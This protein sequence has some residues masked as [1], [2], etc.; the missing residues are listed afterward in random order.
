[1]VLSGLKW[2]WGM[3][4]GGARRDPLPRAR[5]VF[6]RR[7]F[8]HFKQTSLCLNGSS[9][10]ALLWPEYCAPQTAR[11]THCALLGLQYPGTDT[12]ERGLEEKV[13]NQKEVNAKAVG[14]YGPAPGCLYKAIFWTKESEKDNYSLE[15]AQFRLQNSCHIFLPQSLQLYLSHR[16]LCY[17]ILHVF[18]LIHL[19]C[20]IQK[21]S[22]PFWVL[23]TSG[24]LGC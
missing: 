21:C 8:F 16:V 22:H 14:L 18:P 17:L 10:P 9:E 4:P 19:M 13:V 15:L 7:L 6:E 23:R 12:R 5:R 20:A 2:H 11:G 24:T 3:H 1:M